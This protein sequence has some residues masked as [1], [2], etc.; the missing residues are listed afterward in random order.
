MEIQCEK[1]QNMSNLD[2][3]YIWGA[4]LH[5][6]T[7]DWTYP[8]K[9]DSE[10]CVDKNGVILVMLVGICIIIIRHQDLF[11]NEIDIKLCFR[12]IG[13]TGRPFF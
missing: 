12:H 3:I 6:R 7:A 10:S 8:I 2:S 5:M 11:I 4:L 13:R 9:Q 1:V